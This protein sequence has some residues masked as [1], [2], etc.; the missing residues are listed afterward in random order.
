MIYAIVGMPG[1]GKSVLCDHLRDRGLPVVYFGGLVLDEVARRNLP[2][3]A[4]AERE[5]REALRAEHGMAAI[6]QLAMPAIR[7][8]L[9]RGAS[10][11]ID[12]L[13]SFSEYKALKAAFD[14]RLLVVAVCTPAAL[15]HS[16]LG[17][18][19]VRPLSPSEAAR[20]DIS[21]I[22]NLEKGGPIAIAD[23]YIVN[24]DDVETFRQRIDH[25]LR[26]H[27]PTIG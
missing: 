8:H 18:R 14:A 21:E 6:A 1:S 27:M 11:V 3:T 17:Q 12:G 4:E 20:R 9:D 7:G 24:D 23:V 19:P 26:D 16:R 25:A 13:Y 10:V 2:R 5:V 22:E 15:R